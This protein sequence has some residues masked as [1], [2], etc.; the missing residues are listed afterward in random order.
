V[1]VF[2]ACSDHRLAKCRTFG[3]I[4]RNFTG[5][6]QYEGGGQQ[7][8]ECDERGPGHDQG[9]GFFLEFSL[10]SGAFWCKSN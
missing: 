1:F 3:A 6:V 2:N 10:W 9:W 7:V 8:A 5:G 4:A